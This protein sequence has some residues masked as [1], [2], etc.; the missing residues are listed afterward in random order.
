MEFQLSFRS[1][2]G[3]DKPESSG[4]DLLKRFLGNNCALSDAEDNF[5]GLL[6]RGD[7]SD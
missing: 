4:L 7:I 1:K 5:S 2:T 6:N 3:K